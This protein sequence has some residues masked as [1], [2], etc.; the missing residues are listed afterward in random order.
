MP[1]GLLSWTLS[2]LRPYRGRVW[3]LGFLSLLEIGLGA[4][5]PWPLAVVLDNVLLKKPFGASVAGMLKPFVEPFAH[6]VGALAGGNQIRLLV[7]VVI[8]G[9]LLQIM[10]QFASMFHTQV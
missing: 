5:Q 2:F 4:L 8:A 7:I 1:P 3:L 9:V 6:G 10:N